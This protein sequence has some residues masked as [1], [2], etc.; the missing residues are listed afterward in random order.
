MRLSY[1]PAVIK[2]HFI[3]M[4]KL[5][6]GYIKSLVVVLGVLSLTALSCGQSDNGQPNESKIE[7]KES[8]PRPTSGSGKANSTSTVTGLS[9]KASGPTVINLTWNKVPNAM[10]YWVY[11]GNKVAAIIPAANHTDKGVK[12]GTTYTYSIAAVV[13]GALAPKSDSVT[14][15]TPR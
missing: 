8:K 12:A 2:S 5:N 14:V 11:R 1:I 4:K 10:G 3:S 15:T 13:D 6:N 9:A 7:S